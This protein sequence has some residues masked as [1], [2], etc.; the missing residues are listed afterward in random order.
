[1]ELQHLTCDYARY[2]RSAGG[3]ASVL[4]G[5]FCLFSY[6]TAGWLPLTTPWRAVL[7]VLPLVWLLARWGMRRH[8]Y[9]AAGHVGERETPAERRTHRWCVGV[10]LLVAVMVT[11]SAWRE[12]SGH[13]TAGAAGYVLM[14]WLLV[15]ACWRWLRSPLEYFVGVFL[16]CQAGLLCIGRH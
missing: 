1:D 7:V 11:M 13:W 5:V 9:Q 14:V 12:S 6:L 15:L 16:F 3:L 10:T 4:G 8:Y 2:S